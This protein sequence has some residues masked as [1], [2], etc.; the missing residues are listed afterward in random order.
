MLRV[1]IKPDLLRWARERAGFE[2]DDLVDRFEKLPQW[3]AGEVRPTLKQVENFA[4]KV[5]VAI[6]FLF[7]PEPPNEILPIP[8]FRTIAGKPVKR[9]SPNLLDAIYDCQERQEWYEG[10]V[11]AE[12][13]PE[14]AF[15]DSATLDTL[16]ETVAEEMRS[17]LGFDLDARQECPTWT[18]ALRLFIRQVDKA[19]ILVMKS[20]VVGSNAHRPLDPDEFRG[21]ALSD[22]IAPLVFVNGRDTKAAQMFTLA[23]ELAHL[24]LGESALTKYGVKP[25][26]GLKPEEVW[27]NKVAAEFLVP[28]ETFRPKLKKSESLPDALPR[29]ARMYKVS[30][31][32]I[33]RRLLDAGWLDQERFDRAWD[34]ENKRLKDLA[35]TTKRKGGNFYHTTLTRVG[36]R[37]AYALV[38]ST[39]EGGT[40]YRDAYRMLGIQK[41]E[42]FDTLGRE[43]GMIV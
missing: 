26:R 15:V 43:V 25:K 14:F 41:D 18:E 8:D 24:W 17:T 11:R 40:L 6:G 7:L 34:R 27:C 42:A 12:G 10:F 4:K 16:P 9:P 33:L 5:N 19:G 22:P 2:Q 20:G 35:Q 31:L 23:H 21:F 32:V 3:E 28:L 36:H 29:L 38:A 30:S 1:A 13:Y 37:F 39:L